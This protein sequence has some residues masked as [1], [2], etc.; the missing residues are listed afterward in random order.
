MSKERLAKTEID[1]E[2]SKTKSL[3]PVIDTLIDEAEKSR[4]TTEKTGVAIMQNANFNTTSINN[5]YENTSIGNQGNSSF[6]SNDHWTNY[7]IKSPRQ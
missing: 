1:M 4:K 3:T 7:N 6:F 5:T 2:I